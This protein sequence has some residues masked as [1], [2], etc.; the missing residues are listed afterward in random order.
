MHTNVVH[1]HGTVIENNGLD[2]YL[3]DRV[4]KWHYDKRGIEEHITNISGLTG[5]DTDEVKKKLPPASPESIPWRIGES[6]AQCFLEDC[7]FAKFPYPPSRDV[8]NPN[9][10]LAGAD[11]IGFYHKNGETTFLFGDVKTSHEDKHPPRVITEQKMGLLTQMTNLKCNHVRS[12]MVYWLMHI[13]TDENDPYKQYLD[14][15]IVSY[16]RQNAV[17]LVG[18]LIRDTRPDKTDLVYAFERLK[19]DTRTCLDM[20][21]LYMSV[22]ISSLPQKIGSA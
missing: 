21:A 4:R 1:C 10:S 13:I 9:A 8:K 22:P 14:D 2:A 20:W 19:T 6:F 5:F 7:W 11:I 3:A 18:I 16:V 17:R 15:A 12:S